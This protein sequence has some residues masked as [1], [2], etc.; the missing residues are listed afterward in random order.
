M[1]AWN[2]TCSDRMP[3]EL[4]FGKVTAGPFLSIDFDSMQLNIRGIF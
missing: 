1:I 4:F 3:E 2:Y